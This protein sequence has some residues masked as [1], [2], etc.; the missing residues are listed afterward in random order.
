MKWWWDGHCYVGHEAFSKKQHHCS[1]LKGLIAAKR[2]CR[3]QGGL[4]RWESP[5]GEQMGPCTECSS[6]SHAGLCESAGFCDCG[7]QGELSQNF[8]ELGFAYAT[9]QVMKGLENPGPA[10]P[11]RAVGLLQAA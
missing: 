2:S 7:E 6:S 11:C 3:D 1:G 8:P 5:S 4:L 9:S 10:R